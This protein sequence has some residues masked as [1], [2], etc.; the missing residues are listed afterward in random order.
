MHI[1]VF[2]KQLSQGLAG[3]LASFPA[4]AHM[5]FIVAG[6]ADSFPL[7]VYR[8]WV[9]KWSAEMT[10]RV[11]YSP[12]LSSYPQ[13]RQGERLR[14]GY[15]SGAGF[16][17]SP[18][19]SAVRGTFGEPTHCLAQTATPSTGTACT[20]PARRIR[21]QGVLREQLDLL[22][23]YL[24]PDTEH[25][26]C[27]AELHDRARFEVLCFALKPFLH[28][29]DLRS[30]ISASCDRFLEVGDLQDDRC[31]C[32]FTSPTPN[33]FH[34]RFHAKHIFAVDA[35]FEYSGS[36]LGGL[37][38]TSPI[39]SSICPASAET[40]ESGCSRTGLLHSPSPFSSI[41]VIP[42][43]LPNVPYFPITSLSI[44]SM[45]RSHTGRR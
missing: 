21:W 45:F 31:A 8:D 38:H 1:P 40:T 23:G 30:N 37:T 27:C 4:P 17:R 22:G 5:M 19:S 29:N 26:L 43:S 14:I 6:M 9:D 44:V 3:D 16:Q 34:Q 36:W 42:Q 20:I 39:S 28:G 24:R 35:S 18:G 11:D 32:I 15:V 33:P 12:F 13:Y 2:I 7:R 10:S 25:M 41:Q